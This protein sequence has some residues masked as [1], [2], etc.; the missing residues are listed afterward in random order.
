MQENQ[1]MHS[2]GYDSTIGDGWVGDLLLHHRNWFF[3]LWCF[4]LPLLFR[5][6][7]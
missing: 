6:L 3:L 7:D 1:I 2:R 5:F 4:F